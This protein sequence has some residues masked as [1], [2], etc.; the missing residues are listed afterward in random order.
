MSD[1]AL[2]FQKSYIVKDSK[3]MRGDDGAPIENLKCAICPT[4]FRVTEL[5][6]DKAGAI[7]D[8]LLSKSHRDAASAYQRYMLIS[9]YPVNSKQTNPSRVQGSGIVGRCRSSII[10]S[11][12]SL[13]FIKSPFISNFLASRFPPAATLQTANWLAKTQIE[14]AYKLDFGALKE[15]VATSFYYLIVDETPT[16]KNVPLLHVLLRFVDVLSPIPG[17]DCSHRLH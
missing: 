16:S 14:A 17:G 1:Y 13:E 11:G 15:R 4:K 6:R 9:I 7:R 8:H 2:E 3:V 10:Y 12:Q 5:T